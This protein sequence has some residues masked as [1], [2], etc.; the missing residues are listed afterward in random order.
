MSLLIKNCRLYIKDKVHVK[1]ILIKKGKIAKISSDMR[2]SSLRT[3][4]QV[5]EI[6]A[7][8]IIDA[9]NN[10][11][12]PGLIDCHVH[13]REPGLT[14]KEDFLTGSMAA[15]KGG[16][17]T[18]LDMPNT[19][20]PTT[21]LQTLEEKRKMASKSIVNYGFHFGATSN[22]ISDM[23]KVKNISAVKLYMDYTTGDLKV[24]DFEAIR[25]IFSIS[26][27][28][29]VHAEDLKVKNAIDIL[30]KH[31]IKNKLH[32]A[33]VS[34]EEELKHAKMNA[35]KNQ[36][37]VEVTPNHLFMNENDLQNLGSF[38]E[39]KP[40]LKTEQDQ[41]ALWL[42]IKNGIVDIIAS[43]HA[44]HLKEEKEKVNYPFG[45]PGVETMLPLLL[46][47][48]N[49]GKISLPAILKLCCENPAKLF[50]IKNK[51]I[52]KEGYDA[53][54]VIVDLDKRQ[55]VRNEDLMTKC[56][57]SPFDGK[58]LKGWPVTTIV[59]GNVVYDNGEIFDVKAKEI[60]YL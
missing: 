3:R 34:S 14:H 37:T 12:L 26:R 43:D 29:I 38:A 17:T 48:F 8:N 47:A 1:N 20:P 16:V 13:F 59:N 55:A 53:D 18:I 52:L 42:G 41:K 60:D 23:K 36:V 58:I 51:G 44:P 50:R 30:T 9:K 5:G 10:F 22:N 39:M 4:S 33:H 56:K 32:V 24:D 21:T 27:I 35:I 40:R 11:V 57:W 28:T 54:L 46:D 45:V 7:D 15:A 6:F 19:L 31:K 49:A 25:Q 2:V